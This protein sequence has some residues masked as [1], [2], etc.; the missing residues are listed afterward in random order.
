VNRI[1]DIR[2]P[3]IVSKY[4]SNAEW[5]GEKMARKEGKMYI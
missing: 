1:G 3:R 4:E 5:D 2:Q